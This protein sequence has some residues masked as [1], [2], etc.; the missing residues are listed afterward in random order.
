LDE[1]SGGTFTVS[2]IGTFGSDVFTPIMNPPECAILGIGKI[3]KRAWVVEDRI[4]IRPIATLSL[5][6]DHR[7]IDGAVA[8]SFLERIREIIENPQIG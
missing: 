4:E 1:I 3:V 8:A 6:F 2:N 7:I 5:T